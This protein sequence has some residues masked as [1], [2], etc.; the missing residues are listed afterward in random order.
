MFVLLLMFSEV[1]EA[2][3]GEGEG[4]KFIKESFKLSVSDATWY[5]ADGEL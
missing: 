2:E 5:R 3:G 1:I 4:S